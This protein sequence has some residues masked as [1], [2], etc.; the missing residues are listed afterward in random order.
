[1]PFRFIEHCLSEAFTSMRRHW[2]MS[3]AATVSAAISVAIFGLLVLIVLYIRSAVIHESEKVNHMRVYLHNSVTEQQARELQRRIQRWVLVKSVRFV[4][5][6]EG[7]KEMEAAMG[8][9]ISLRNLAGGNPL[10][11]R[12]DVVAV[13]FEDAVECAKRLERLPGVESVIC[14]ADVVRQLS[15]IFGLVRLCGLT[16]VII[17][18]L[19]TLTLIANAIRL[20]IYARR[21]AIRIMQLVGATIWFIRAPLLLEG[22]VYGLIG[23]A[24][25]SLMVYG[26][27]TSLLRLVETNKILLTLFHVA[28]PNWHFFA[29][30]TVVGLIFGLLGSLSAVNQLVRYLS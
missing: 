11:H 8:D 6:D 17:T 20:T 14:M 16:L 9:N 28:V 27:H 12:L 3:M 29:S 24:F 7:L 15:R 10:P 5:K 25:A 1:M 4:H 23:G 19:A 13:N 30:L 18:A 22:L 21:E 2:L 26:A